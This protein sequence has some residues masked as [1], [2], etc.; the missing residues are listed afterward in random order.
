MQ[1]LYDLIFR[2]PFEFMVAII[3]L[4]YMLRDKP[5]HGLYAMYLLLGVNVVAKELGASQMMAGV[6]LGVFANELFRIIRLHLDKEN[7]RNLT[8]KL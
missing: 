1:P 8:P 4:F 2:S 7:R 6:I 3:F 5:G